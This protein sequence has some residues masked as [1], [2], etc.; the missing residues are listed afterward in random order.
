MKMLNKKKLITNI[1]VTGIDNDTM[2]FPT[3]KEAAKFLDVTT[4]M[5]Y[6]AL[7]ENL[8]VRGCTVKKEEV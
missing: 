4:V 8:K 2:T 5:I 7:N 3:V 6:R 1:V